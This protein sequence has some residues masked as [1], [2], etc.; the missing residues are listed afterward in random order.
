MAIDFSFLDA[1]AVSQPQQ[2]PQDGVA[3]VTLRVDAD[4]LLLCDGEH[5]DIELKA[6][7]VKKTQLPVGQHLLEFLS[8]ENPDAKVEKVVD[9]PVAGKS[10]LVMVSELKEALAKFETKAAVALAAKRVFWL[11]IN[12]YDDEMS[13]MMVVRNIL[14][15]SVT[16]ARAKLAKLPAVVIET[17]EKARV[18]GLAR[19]FAKSNVEVAVETRNGL[20]ELVGSDSYDTQKET[21]AKRKAQEEA[22][23]KAAEEA[24]RKAEAEAKRK[25]E[26][27]AKRKAA[28]EE[29][30]RKA[31]QEAKR[32]AAAQEAK[33]KAE[34][35]KR[36]AEEAEEFYNTGEDYFYRRNGKIKKYEEAVKWYRKAVELG[37]TH[38]QYSLGYCYYWG[39][40]VEKDE[41]EAIKWYR[42]AAEQGDAD[43]QYEL[44][45]YYGNVWS[46]IFDDN[47]SCRN[48]RYDAKEAAKWYRK[49]AEQYLKAAEQGNAEAQYSLGVCYLLGNGV[50][51]DRELAFEWFLKAAEQGNASAQYQLGEYYNYGW[52]GR[53]DS[54]LA[55]EW[56]LK[57]AEQGNAKAQYSL[58]RC[59][60]Y[61][62][63][64]EEDKKEALKWYRKAADQGH[65]D[66]KECLETDF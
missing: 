41:E 15:C 21:E 4:A 16:E 25:A 35:A 51:I 50:G 20:G 55:L 1:A 13:A 53:C 14:G 64:V 34:E 48:R 31:A 26:E 3:N 56:Y 60:C 45:D 63:G 27:E 12:G 29:A 19:L 5:I 32:K 47:E 6:G 54:E 44:G 49:A 46:L 24:K 18:E 57:A 38:A 30:K 59:Y 7:V 8:E 11:V 62:R 39:K 28:E 42:K 40:G 33:R 22:D 9:F 37:H 58:G 36:K 23:R 65:S 2:H 52:L 61:G 43:A 66:A 17:E 10:Y